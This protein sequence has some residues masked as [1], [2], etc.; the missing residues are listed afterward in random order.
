MSLCLSAK[1]GAVIGAARPA[2]EPMGG[3]LASQSFL[4]P[5][6]AWTE[7]RDDAEVFYIQYVWLF[8]THAIVTIYF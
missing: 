4:A 5:M 1:S 2:P 8:D 7:L 3:E 6:P